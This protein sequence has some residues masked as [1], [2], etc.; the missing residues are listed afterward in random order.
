MSKT[1]LDVQSYAREQHSASACM[2]IIAPSRLA[3]VQNKL[4][5]VAQPHVLRTTWALSRVLCTRQPKVNCSAMHTTAR[6][7][8]FEKALHWSDGLVLPT[9]FTLAGSAH[10][11]RLRVRVSCCK[12]LLT[13]TCALLSATVTQSKSKDLLVE[14]GVR[15]KALPS[16]ITGV[17]L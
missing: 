16:K 4:S 17:L 6:A 11:T 9:C 10:P 3:R 12:L 7:A 2:K 15:C 14:A 1:N 8:C 13:W 5:P